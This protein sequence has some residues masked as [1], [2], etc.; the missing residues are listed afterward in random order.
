MARTATTI[1]ESRRDGPGASWRVGPASAVG[2]TGVVVIF[3]LLAWR[4]P[5]MYEAL[6]QEDRFVEWLTAGL[7]LAAAVRGAIRAVRARRV[8]DGLVALFCLFVAGEEMSWGQRLLGFMPPEAFLATNAQQEFNLHN[9]KDVFGQPKIV[10]GIALAG[11]GIVLPLMARWRTGSRILAR[12]GSTAPHPALALWLAALVVLLW[13]YPFK[14]T[15]E[16]VELVAGAIFWL[17]TTPGRANAIG[18]L[19]GLAGCA[20]LLSSWSGHV[21]EQALAAV[22]CARAEVRTIASAAVEGALTAPGA[23]MHNRVWIAARESLLIW[24]PVAARLSAVPCSASAS[25]RRRLRYAVDPWGSPYW[26]RVGGAPA[27]VEVYSFGPN[28]RRD[29]H[30]SGDDVAF[31]IPGAREH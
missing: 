29:E 21:G 26:I 9:F 19:L 28:R 22:T 5:S 13:W 8:F 25:A 18:T 14:F 17:A 12:I 15:G 7:F 1:A 11:Y 27:H 23:R 4:R 30:G 3:V 6:L 24:T 2:I 31:A 16:W 10:L 20:A